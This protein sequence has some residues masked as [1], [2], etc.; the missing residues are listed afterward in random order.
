MQLSDGLF[1]TS[2][3]YSAGSTVTRQAEDIRF[4]RAADTQQTAGTLVL[5]GR[6]AVTM[7]TQFFAA[8]SKRLL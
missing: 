1:A 7:A 3:V 4:A 8:D 2:P 5:K 6:N